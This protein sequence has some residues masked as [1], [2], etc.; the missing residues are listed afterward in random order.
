MLAAQN[1]AIEKQLFVGGV[2][3]QNSFQ[4]TDLTRTPTLYRVYAAPHTQG[5]KLIAV[6]AN[7]SNQSTQQMQ[8]EAAQAGSPLSVFI[9]YIDIE[10]VVLN[11]YTPT[12]EKSSSDSAALAALSYLF[13][14]RHIPDV[15]SV[16]MGGEKFPAQLCGGEWLL[17]QGDVV[18][19]AADVESV[20]AELSA[21]RLAPQHFQVASTG[22]PNLL[23]ELPSLADLHAFSPDMTAIKALGRATQTTGLI[24][25]SLQAERADVAFRAFGPLKGFDEDA[26]SSN[27]FACLV[28]AL[29]VRGVLPEGPMV[30]GLQMMPHL[31]SRLTAQYLPQESGASDVWVGGSAVARM[32]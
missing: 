13:E 9:Q 8:A 15:I 16:Y 23:A 21:L 20:Q 32:S 17:R 4:M 1:L 14:Q 18:V 3:S 19:E 26:A 12:R 11:I 2:L 28:G 29:S 31:P 7:A 24:V 30:R 22:R 6:F 5:G 10:D 25:Y 27:M